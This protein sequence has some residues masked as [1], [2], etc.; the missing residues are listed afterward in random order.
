[1]RSF[2]WIVLI[3]A[4][5]IAGLQ[6]VCAQAADSGA[7]RPFG[8]PPPS[9]SSEERPF[10]G[11]PP[12]NRGPK[13]FGKKCQLQSQSCE[14]GKPQKLGADCRCPGDESPGKIVE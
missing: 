8:G 2:R 3:A 6:A 14:L 7:E 9:R 1:M 5:A 10:G 11:P 4:V 13:R 12:Q